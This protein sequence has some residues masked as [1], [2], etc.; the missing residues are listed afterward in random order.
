MKLVTAIIKSN[1]VESLKKSLIKF[2]TQGLI[3]T[4]AKSYTEMYYDAEYAE[5]I[6]ADELVEKVISAIS[7]VV[8]TEKIGDGKVFITD[9]S[10][11]IPIR[12]GERR[13]E[14]I[15]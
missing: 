12:K 1:K 11:I 14:A 5:I 7:E 9:I 15:N 4:K 8:K 3:I 6:V 10:K 2:N 13:E